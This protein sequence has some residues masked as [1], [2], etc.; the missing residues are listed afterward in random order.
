MSG[1]TFLAV[2]AVSLAAVL[3]AACRARTPCEIDADCLIVC[4]C[5][6]VETPATVGGFPCTAGTCGG[7]HARQRDCVA[8]C[9]RYG[10]IPD[11]EDGDSAPSDDD[12][13]AL[14]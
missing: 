7:G 8:I 12:S 11:Y 2:A 3:S 1:R 10:S 13:S 6:G 14:R 4:D 9:D 5:V